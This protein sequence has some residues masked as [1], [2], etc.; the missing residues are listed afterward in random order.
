[1]KKSSHGFT[2][3]EL[4]IV[5]VVIAI[6]AAISIIAYNGIQTRARETTL[7]SDLSNAAKQMELANADASSYPTSLPSGVKASSNVIMSLSQTTNGF[8]INGEYSDSLKWRY[9][10]TSGGL[11][12]GLCPGAVI[13]GSESGINPNLITNTD[14]S[15]TWS[16]SAQVTAGRTLSTRPGT[17]GDPYPNRPVLVLTN[18]ASTATG[19]A[20]IQTSSI[21]RTPIITGKNFTRSYYIRKTGTYNQNTPIFGVVDAGGTNIALSYSGGTVPTSA[22]WQKTSFTSAV[23]QNA[24]STNNMYLAVNANAFT[25]AGWTLEFQGFELREQ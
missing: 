11:Q 15:G 21:N 6:L 22:S 7:K 25:T 1:M 10:S 9:D 13:S 14:F 4:L 17:T 23:L 5:I 3:V 2:I 24:V 19:W 20:I 8:C 18:T 16:F 12:E